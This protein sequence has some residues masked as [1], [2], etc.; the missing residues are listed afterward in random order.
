M[1]PVEVRRIPLKI[2]KPIQIKSAVNVQ[3]NVNLTANTKA[4]TIN[5]AQPI[6]TEQTLVDQQAMAA[7][8]AKVEQSHAREVQAAAIGKMVDEY[9]LKIISKIRRNIV[10][11]P[12]VQDN[13]QSEFDVILIPGGSVLST[14]LTKPSGNSAYDEAVDRAISKAQPLPLPSDVSQFNKFRELHLTFT[15]KE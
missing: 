7:Q 13:M 8:V 15:P 14:S 10:M 9:K 6:R 12:D 11:P 1:K 5:Q 2:T 3:R 4:S